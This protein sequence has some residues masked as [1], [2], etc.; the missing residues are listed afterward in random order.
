[1]SGVRPFVHGPRRRLAALGVLLLAL[2][3]LALVV[4]D[5]WDADYGFVAVVLAQGVAY[6]LAARLLPALGRGR[7]DLLIVLG[8]A[9]ALRLVL[10]PAPTLHSTDVYRYVWDG[11]VQAAGIDPYRYVPADPALAELRDDIVF[12]QINR[13]DYAVTA[14]PPVAQMAFFLFTRIDDGVVGIRIGL[15]LLEAAAMAVLAWLLRASGRPPAALLLYAW[16]PLPVWEVA[17]DAHVD[18]GMAAFLVFALCACVRRQRLATG[19]LLAGSVL[20]KPLTLAA[21]PAFWRPWDWRMPVAFVAAAVAACLVYAEAGLGIFRFLP[22]Y[23][24]EE[25][26]ATG[27]G[28]FAVTILERLFGPHPFHLWLYA[29]GSGLVLAGI[30]IAAIRERAAPT[31]QTMAARTQMLMFA[32]LLVLSPNYPWYFL[33][34]VPLGCLAPWLPARV[35]TLLAIVLYAAPPIDGHPRTLA[36]QGLVYGG[37]IAALL[38]DAL[39]RGRRTPISERAATWDRGE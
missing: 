30:A 38:F 14:Y 2:H 4:Q 13:A 5:R 16:H 7:P 10:V 34:L 3:A 36:V 11:R 28:F 26:V 25:G 19:A 32:A 27:S 6:L 39:A 31:A 23:F 1:V 33:V 18:G 15:L 8:V 29:L 20:F 12:P 21:L 37:A 35:L 24:G 9:V 17:G 22:S